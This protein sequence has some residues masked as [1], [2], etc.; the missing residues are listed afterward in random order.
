M[1]EGHDSSGSM[2]W[3]LTY[4]D[5]ITLLLAFFVIMYA[6]SKVDAKRYQAIALSIR[7]AFGTPA[8]VP[9]AGPQSLPAPDPVGALVEALRAQLAEDVGAGR[10]QI[11]ATRDAI[12][13][14]FQDAVFFERGKADLTDRARRILDRLAGVV[15]GLPNGIEA[16]GHTD[17]LPIR[18]LQFPSNWELSVARATAVVRYLGE[19]HGISP[20]RLAARGLGEHKP[21]YPNDAVRGEPR[22]RRVEIR[23]LTKT[24][25]VRT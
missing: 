4:A 8:Q 7:G 15:G 21:L 16:E 23:I 24:Y 14:R 12:V 5:M 1:S 18:S 3:L 2:R 13:L 20:L 6:I 17:T 25:D 10:I 9:A 19:A 11:E 22:N